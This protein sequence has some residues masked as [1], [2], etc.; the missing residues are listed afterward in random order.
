MKDKENICFHLETLSRTLLEEVNSAQLLGI[1]AE[2][3]KVRASGGRIYTLGNG[4]S[5]ANAAHLTLHLRQADLDVVDI[6]A[7]V[8]YLTAISND[9][10]YSKVGEQRIKK[11]GRSGDALLVISGSGMSANILCALS[12]AKDK[13]IKTL[14]LLGFSGGIA[15]M[16]CDEA[17]I[18]QSHN[19]AIVEDVHSAISHILGNLLSVESQGVGATTS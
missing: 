17:V 18:L 10:A 12:A 7:D 15:K 8:S 9:I 11:D 6:L 3:R 5:Y 1:L 19:Y 2:L 4:G 14:G 13:G 16:L